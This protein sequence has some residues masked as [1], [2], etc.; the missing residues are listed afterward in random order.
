M[1]IKIIRSGHKGAAIALDQEK[2][3]GE[4]T[5]SKPDD[6]LMI[7]DHTE[8]DPAYG[9]QGVGNQLLQ[10]IVAMAREQDTKIIPLCPF[11]KAQFQKQK[12]IQDVLK[13]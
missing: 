8:V 2:Q 7:I 4:M 1:E 12:D 11:A 6:H 5:Y 9:G 10:A 13:N 3:I